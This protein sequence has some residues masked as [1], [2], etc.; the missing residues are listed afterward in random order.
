MSTIKQT[1]PRGREQRKLESDKHSF[2]KQ[3]LAAR[4]EGF[5]RNDP[6]TNPVEVL[7]SGLSYQP[8]NQRFHVDVVGEEK[9]VRQY[10]IDKSKAITDQKRAVNIERENQRWKE[11][12]KVSKKEETRLE[13]ARANHKKNTSR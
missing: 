2:E 10:Q 4:K 7:E 8:N 1:K 13:D 5:Q 11:I 12:E 9:A 3:R 6:H